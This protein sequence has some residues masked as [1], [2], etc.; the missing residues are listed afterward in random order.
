MSAEETTQSAGPTYS[1]A[2]RSINVKCLSV[3]LS[4][5]YLIFFIVYLIER[6]IAICFCL[7]V[8]R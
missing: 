2:C 1:N 8:K 6:A 4:A 7:E 5:F 3:F